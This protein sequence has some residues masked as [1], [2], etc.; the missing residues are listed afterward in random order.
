MD[1]WHVKSHPLNL[2]KG[3]KGK[4]MRRAEGAGWLL[5]F[6][7]KSGRREGD[8]ENIYLLSTFYGDRVVGFRRATVESRSTW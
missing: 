2:N 1:M 3:K 4:K 5:V 8:G 6:T 7:Q